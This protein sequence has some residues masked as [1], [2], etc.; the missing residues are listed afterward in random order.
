M[1][2]STNPKSYR[3]SA[4]T[5]PPPIKWAL[6]VTQSW[7]ESD[8]SPPATGEVRNVLS[9]TSTS[10]HVL[11]YGTGTTGSSLIF[12]VKLYG[13]L[14][15]F[16]LKMENLRFSETSVTI[17]QSAWRK[18]PD[19]FYFHQFGCENLKTRPVRDVFRVPNPVIVGNT[20]RL[21]GTRVQKR[22]PEPQLKYHTLLNSYEQVCTMNFLP[23]QTVA[24]RLKPLSTLSR[25]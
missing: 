18:I 22:P 25:H 6:E 14:D 4:G 12:R 19:I 16:T 10:P 15:L 23:K 17:Y 21:V 11:M 9:Y 3:Y 24:T 1:H 13:L 2:G 5:I 20:R 8:H 7:R